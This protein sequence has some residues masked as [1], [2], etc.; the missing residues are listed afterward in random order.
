MFRNEFFYN[1]HG[2]RGQTQ[3]YNETGFDIY[4][5]LDNV[6]GV[7][8]DSSIFIDQWIQRGVDASLDNL[9]V[10]LLLFLEFVSIDTSIVFLSSELDQMQCFMEPNQLANA[11]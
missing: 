1:R 9:V 6:C 3:K 5:K 7:S 2:V 11:E 4:N 8:I 10:R